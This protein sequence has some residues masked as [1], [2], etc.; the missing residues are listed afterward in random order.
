MAEM[1]KLIGE[2]VQSGA[3]LATDGLQASSKGARVK[4]SE[5][6]FAVTDGPFTET[7]ELIG[8]FAIFQLQSKAEA[9][10][11]SER[12]L[13]VGATVRWRFARCRI[14]RPSRARKLSGRLSRRAREDS[15][16]ALEPRI[17]HSANAIHDADDPRKV[18]MDLPRPPQCPTP[19]ATAVAPP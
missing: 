5:G 11:L 6:K 8:G 7:K 18:T 19:K 15:R 3:L 2:L 10:Q 1:G 14:T 12:F 4:L 17:E 16:I 13:K 9:I